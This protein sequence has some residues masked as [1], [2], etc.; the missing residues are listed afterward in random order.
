VIFS[1]Y[2]VS[3]TYKQAKKQSE[4]IPKDQKFQTS[5][6]HFSTPKNLTLNCNVEIPNLT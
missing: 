3:L 4:R 5:K 6:L 2:Q 1:D